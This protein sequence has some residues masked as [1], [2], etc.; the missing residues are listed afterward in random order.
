MNI[1][2]GGALVGEILR[3][4]VYGSLSVD[5]EMASNLISSGFAFR[6]KKQV[7]DENGHGDR[8]SHGS[9]I[10][11]HSTELWWIKWIWKTMLGKRHIGNSMN[12]IY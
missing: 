6:V 11:R 7:S 5:D 8:H 10:T 2:V 4:V 12:E 3:G 1:M 9:N